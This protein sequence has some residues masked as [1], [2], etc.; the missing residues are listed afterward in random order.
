MVVGVNHQQNVWFGKVTLLAYKFVSLGNG[1]T[2]ALYNASILFFDWMEY[3]HMP[4][5]TWGD[6]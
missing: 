2:S 3:V 6:G 1:M 4:N 5:T